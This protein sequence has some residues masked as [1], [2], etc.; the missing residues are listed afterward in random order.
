MLFEEISTREAIGWKLAHSVMLAGKRIAKGTLIDPTLADTMV[1]HQIDRVSAF[2]LEDGDL[3]ENTTAELIAEALTG[4]GLRT[5]K[6]THGRCNLH[7]LHDGVFIADEAA[8]AFEDID[9][10]VAIATIRNGTRVTAGKLIAT[11]K[12]I[13]YAVEERLAKG[14]TKQLEKLEVHGFKPFSAAIISSGGATNSKLVE[15]TKSRLSSLG[16]SSPVT[17]DCAHTVTAVKTALLSQADSDCDLILLTGISAISDIRDVIPAAL[18]AAGGSVTHLGMPVDPGNLL[19]LG[20]LAG[21]TAI[22]IPRCAASPMLNGFDWVL[23][24]FAARLPIDSR[25][26]Q[27]MAIGGLL[28][29]VTERPEPRSPTAR[30]ASH[31]T[32]AIVLAAGKSSR[33]GQSHKLLSRIGNATVIEKTLSSLASAGIPSPLVITGHRADEIAAAIASPDVRL[34]QNPNYASGMA[35]SLSAGV[36]A[37]EDDIAQCFICLG[38]MPFVRAETFAALSKSAANISEAEIFIPT[39]NGKRG[40]PVL[41]RHTQFAKLRSVTGDKG[42]RVLI[43]D[44]DFIVIEVPVDDPGILID[45]DTPEALKQFGITPEKTL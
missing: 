40:N 44:Q 27:K 11:V 12:I 18:K 19:M 3:C 10:S 45:L 43:R 28:K 32:A 37:L 42:G 2:R 38:D 39:F 30:P 14:I 25:A 41:W 5:A 24:R 26:L 21:K 13:P 17:V 4:I 8:S 23:E 6:P 29:E 22:G 36:G 20:T 33:S 9:P 31:L 15:A 7:A 16:T 1:A 34:I 35:S